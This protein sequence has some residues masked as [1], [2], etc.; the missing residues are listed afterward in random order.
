MTQTAHQLAETVQSLKQR[1]KAG[2]LS[3]KQY[4]AGLLDV[5]KSLTESLI[6]ELDTIDDT[7]VRTQIPLLLVIL[8]EQI[9]AFGER[10]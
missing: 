9:A 6:G 1:R 5:L 10:E 7:D 2:E 8:D 3:P 4:Y